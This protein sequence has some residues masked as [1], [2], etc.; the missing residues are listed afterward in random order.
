[1]KNILFELDQSAILPATTLWITE[2]PGVYKTTFS[3]D[4]TSSIATAYGKGYWGYGLYGLAA[5]TDRDASPRK[6]VARIGSIVVDNIPYALVDTYNDL[7]SADET[8]YFNQA[9]Q[10]L[11]VRFQDDRR[12]STFAAMSLG[13]TEGYAQKA[14]FYDGVFYDSR[15]VSGPNLRWQKDPLF[16]GKISIDTFNTTLNNS[17]H[18]FDL[19]SQL[20]PFGNAIRIYFGDE[21][22]IFDNFEQVFTGFFESFSL[23]GDYCVITGADERKRMS[24]NIPTNKVTQTDFPNLPDGE[25]VKPLI[26]GTVHKSETIPID[27]EDGAAVEFRHIFID[28][29]FFTTIGLVSDVYVENVKIDGADYTVDYV[30]GWVT[31]DEAAYQPGQAV[32]VDVEGSDIVNP[33]EI[34]EDLIYKYVGF[35]YNAIYYDTIQWEIVKAAVVQEMQLS[36]SYEISLIEAI[37]K[38]VNTVFGLF[39]IGTDGRFTFKLRDTAAAVVKTIQPYEFLEPPVVA[40]KQDEYISSLRVGYNV[41]YGSGRWSYFTID[42][43]EDELATL[44]NR[45]KTQDIFTYLIDE[46]DAEAAAIEVYPQFAGIFPTFTIEVAADSIDVQLEDNIDVYAYILNDGTFGSVKLEVVGVEYDFNNSRQIITGR[47]IDYNFDIDD[48]AQIIRKLQIGRSYSQE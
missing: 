3:W 35:E 42:D 45:Q 38:V 39:L 2:D 46:T 19:L 47:Y 28:V 31:I 21:D 4:N 48:A 29:D 32:W 11:Y 33:L 36:I 14:G 40:F 17:D 30:N 6:P 34:I 13:A 10:I 27:D 41:G 43:D 12:P 20:Y 24:R 1:M 7:F 44:Y 37:E 23:S 9:D 22:D 26:Y 16:F 5:N 8:F 18:Y 15:I 25:W